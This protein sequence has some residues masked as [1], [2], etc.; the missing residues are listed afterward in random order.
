MKK[1]LKV[2]YHVFLDKYWPNSLACL[3]RYNLLPTIGLTF[4]ELHYN[5]K[6]RIVTKSIHPKMYL[7][8]TIHL[9]SLPKCIF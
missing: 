8:H 3:Q 1:R 7:K 5:A 2:V 6:A 9:Q 4:Y